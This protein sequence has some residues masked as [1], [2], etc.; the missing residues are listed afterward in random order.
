MFRHRAADLQPKMRADS[1]EPL[2]PTIAT[3]IVRPPGPT[4]AQGI[5][6][7]GLGPPDLELAL[8]QH[9]AYAVALEA[10]GVCLVRLPADPAHPDSTFVE[11]TAVILGREAILT[12]PGAESRRGEVDSIRAA[13]L[14]LVASLEAIE[15]PGTLDGGDVLETDR[16]FLIGISERTNEAGARRLVKWL[17]ARGR[18]AHL[19]A[20]GGM[21]GLLHLKTGISCVAGGLAAAV[22]ALAPA[23]RALGLEVIPVEPEESYAANAIRANGR[24]LLPSGAPV[25]SR[26]LRARGC[27]VVPLEMSE[28]EKMDGGLSCLSLR[29]PAGGG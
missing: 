17:A 27:A 4:F 6:R 1:M 13:L 11:D 9:A 18:H 8:A 7:A 23:A 24:V 3:A 29:L 20:I 19:V 15:P 10:A 14:P 12:R 22:P 28:F 2:E 26:R 21:P 25:L 16:G 5:T